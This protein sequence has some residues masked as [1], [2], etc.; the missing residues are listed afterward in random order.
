MIMKENL[1]ENLRS[2]IL[3]QHFEGG[4]KEEDE[5]SLLQH[6]QPKKTHRIVLLITVSIFMGYASL[7]LLQHR[8]STKMCLES[9]DVYQHGC[10]MNYVGNLI[11]RIA[12]NFVFA[13]VRPRHRVYI[14]L[15]SM[16]FSMSLLVNENKPDAP[17]KSLFHNEC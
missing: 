10:S 7:V 9:S 12:H 3:P 17:R 1:N 8:L 4:D 6:S 5:E 2:K 14:S 13:K 11:F 15:L 16:C